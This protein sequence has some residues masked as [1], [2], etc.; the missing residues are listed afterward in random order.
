MSEK[1]GRPPKLLV[2]MSEK[3]GRPPKLLVA[4]RAE[5]AC[6]VLRAAAGLGWETVAVAPEDDRSCAH[7]RLADQ[8][9][10]L[11]GRGPAAYL[12]I[13]RLVEVATA[14]DCTLVHPGYG[15][16][17][18]NAE[19][20]AAVEAAGLVFV[21]PTPATI[22]RFG[23]KAAARSLA[24]ELAVP[25]L[26]GTGPLTGADEARD[27]VDAHGAAM[28]KAV[29]GGGGRG[30]RPVSDPGQ[31]VAAFERCRSEAAAAFGNDEVYAEQ[32]ISAARHLEVQ[33]IGDGTGRVTHLWER[34]CTLQRQNQKL[35]ELA[36]A[37]GLDPDLR[38]R[39]I[40]AAL[41]L[42]E[43]V[44]YRSLGTFEFLVDS[45][46]GP[47]AA[48]D[49]YFIEAN[50]RIQVEHTVTEE[51][52]GVDLVQS[53][54]RLALGQ[55]LTDV[56]L[57]G[58]PEPTGL[59]L[60]LRINTETMQSD[61]TARPTGGTFTRFTIPAGGP[62]RHGV[63]TDTHGYAGYITSAAY[64][65]LLAKVIVHVPFLDLPSACQRAAR[66]LI[67]FD[68]AGVDTNKAFLQALI[69][70]ADVAA[71]AVTTRYIAEH[72]QELVFE[73]VA[74]ARPETDEASREAAAAGTLVG[75]RVDGSDPLAVLAL[76][77]QPAGSTPA[78]APVAPGTVEAGVVAA[79]IQGTVVAIDVAPGDE[80]AAGAPLVVMEAMKME[81][82]VVAPTPGT[83]GNVHVAVGDPVFEGHPLLVL[84]PA[85]DSAPAA[86]AAGV[87]DLD[88][89]HIRAD[90]AESIERHGYGLDENRPEAVAK[91]HATG[92]RTARE[93]LADL[94]DEGSFTEWG[95]LVVAAQRKRRSRE[96][97]IEKTPGDGL[98]GGFGTVN[99]ELFGVASAATTPAAARATL[100]MV[101][102]YDYMVLAG[103]Q[104]HNN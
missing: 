1:P 81:H 43:A 50:T 8:F 31:A 83:V 74:L 35:V 27:F 75:T 11:H 34:E 78:P 69:T 7:V 47:P 33:V 84:E 12:D 13:D 60:Q 29:A 54:L 63:R 57:A 79:P 14:T 87:D 67:E 103:T 62:L 101:V 99:G 52:T 89:D 64:D 66:A 104:G 5:I 40:A 10:P 26:A 17:A 6:R 42:A 49:F 86:A 91:R 39:L 18:E 102:S 68:I 30:M 53:Q 88:L 90:L 20:A 76:G 22:A 44:D 55:T 77:K 97:L 38:Q 59:A 2:A 9:V 23:D 82:V 85:D 3:P 94:V 72:A 28:F 19:F 73:A 24:A 80:V 25:I 36:P 58:P 4:N 21:G 16:L 46:P 32:L 61:G 51:I 45:R 37:P 96:E 71:N 95:P 70:R 92:R 93:N 98:I 15:F 48:N 100:T 56:G 41:T 65:S